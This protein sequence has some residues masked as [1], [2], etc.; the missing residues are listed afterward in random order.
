MTP[1]RQN[2]TAPTVAILGAGCSGTAVARELLEQGFEGDIHLID[3][4]SDFSRSQRWCF[5]EKADSP[6]GQMASHSW[7][8][9]KVDDL[10]MATTSHSERYRYFH[11]PS[12]QYFAREHA[13]LA[14]STHVH[15]HLG[16]RVLSTEPLPNGHTV[17]TGGLESSN[18]S[19]SSNRVPLLGDIPILGQLFRSD[20]ESTSET[21]LLVFIRPTI[22]RDDRFADLRYLSEQDVEA[23]GL[24]PDVPQ[25]EP[26]LMH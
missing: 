19:E 21:T 5:W 14:A 1:S 26:V 16:E 4:R 13:K 15:L 9:W 24:P 23:A 8:C 25:S 6:L 3:A 2:G 7:D 12:Q 22:L 11:I 18:D 17:V 20:Q 10:G